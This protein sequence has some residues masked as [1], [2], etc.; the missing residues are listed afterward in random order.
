MRLLVET[1]TIPR[2]PT[3][4]YSPDQEKQGDHAASEAEEQKDTRKTAVKAKAAPKAAAEPV[5]TKTESPGT[6]AKAVLE[7]LHRRTTADLNSTSKS[8]PARHSTPSASEPDE[9][10]EAEEE[11]PEP[12]E[13]LS[14]KQVRARKDA[15]ARYM[16]FSRSLTSKSS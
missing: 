12:D 1:P 9:P 8:T 10:D 6:N 5:V 13:E 14:L 7:N 3:V 16:R 11:A 15:H 2:S 4:H